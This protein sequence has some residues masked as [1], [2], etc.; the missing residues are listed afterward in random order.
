MQFGLFIFLNRKWES[1]S[2]EMTNFIDYYKK[3]DKNVWILLFPEGTDF[4]ANTKNKSDTF[5]KKNNLKIYENLLVPRHR[6]LIHLYDNMKER[7]M[8]DS[9]FDVTVAYDRPIENEIELLFKGKFPKYIN[10]Y[11]DV[12]NN[13]ILSEEW[14]YKRWELKESMIKRFLL[15]L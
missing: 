12:V 14:L 11:I 3:I 15:S 1:D 6:G 8:M 5:A 2:I 10:F 9:I 13:E 7:K 4:T